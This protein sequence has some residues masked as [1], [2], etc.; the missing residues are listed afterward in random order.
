MILNHSKLQRCCGLMLVLLIVVAALVYAI[1][2]E[3][4]HYENR[5]TTM[6]TPTTPVGEITGD[7]VLTQALSVP[8]DTLLSV[9]LRA[10]TYAR[11]NTGTLL[12]ELLDGEGNLLHTQAV[13]ISQLQ[14]NA[15]F[16]FS[17]PQPLPVP[18]S[19]IVLR[20][21]AP[22]SQPGNAVTLYAGNSISATRAEVSAD[23]DDADVLYLNGQP[24]TVALCTQVS[25]R[26]DLWFGDVYGY[27]AAGV[28]VLAALFFLYLLHCNKVGKPFWVLLILSSL[29]R[30]HFL[31]EQLV[32][33]DFKTKYRRSVLGVI[34]SFLNPLLTMLVQYVVFSTLFKSDIPNFALYLLSGI[35]TYSFFSEA[36]NMTL[37]SIVSN[38]SLITKVYVPKYIYPLTRVIS[39][40]VNFLFALIPLLGVM[41]FTRSPITW[42]LLLMPLGILCLFCLSL[43]V[44]LLLS[45]AMV[46]FRDTQFLWTVVSMIWMYLT[47]VFYPESIIP[48]QLLP[49]YR[50]N[51]LYQILAFF[52]AIL[53]EGVSP[54]PS[55][56]LGVIL[57]ALIPLLLGAIVF[58]KNQN[59]F[60]LYL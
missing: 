23:L 27:L 2:G 19:G 26:S 49:V 41:L 34:W 22:D 7:T 40:T 15:N 39:S 17:L 52:R 33:R 38:S 29:N 57:S 44:G 10:A 42:A 43:G 5:Q 36:T 20:I 24:Q 35:V 60:I 53:L 18:G 12:L 21:T 11:D 3:Q 14:D 51:P 47:P 58:R 48:T 16:T 8:G 55:C 46:Y 4:F 28:V 30:Y 37:S 56:Y 59:E 1:G 6:L 9:T 54:S 25:A 32:A 13:D 31:M 50:C 45:T